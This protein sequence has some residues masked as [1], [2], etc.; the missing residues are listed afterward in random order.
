MPAVG[1]VDDSGVGGVAV[2]FVLQRC[3]WA[4]SLTVLPMLSLSNLDS[5]KEL[6]PVNA[7]V[8]WPIEQLEIPIELPAVLLFEELV[9]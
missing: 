7:T 2:V 6:L 3:C 5:L 8:V 9:H 4:L 1:V